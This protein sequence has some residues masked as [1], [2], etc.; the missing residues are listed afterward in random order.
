MTPFLLIPMNA[1]GSL[2]LFTA[3]I[4]AEKSPLVEFLKPIATLRPLARDL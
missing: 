2:A 4:A 3:L 1:A